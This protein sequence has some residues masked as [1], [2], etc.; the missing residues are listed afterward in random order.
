MENTTAKFDKY[1]SVFIPAL[2][3]D[4][5]VLTVYSESQRKARKFDYLL[6]LKDGTEFEANEED[7]A[8]TL[9]TASARS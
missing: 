2:Q 7:I 3:K 9:E 6:V 4:A 5:T 8:Q 1:E